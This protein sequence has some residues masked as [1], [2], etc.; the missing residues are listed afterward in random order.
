M[1]WREI[2]CKEADE[3]IHGTPGLTVFSSFT[4]VDG[5]SPIGYGYP[6]MRTTWGKGEEEILREE[7]AEPYPGT[8]QCHHYLK[9]QA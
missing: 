4:D 7:Y 5:Y 9:K 8:K 1:S 2:T 3:V 6:V